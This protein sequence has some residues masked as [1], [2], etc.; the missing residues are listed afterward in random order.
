MQAILKVN[1]EIKS[2]SGSF[3][4][5]FISFQIAPAIAAGCSVVLKPSPL[6]SLSCLRF[7]E[8]T[9]AANIPSGIF[10]VLTG[11]PPGKFL[12]CF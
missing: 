6:A 4:P 1:L 5:L 12:S 7:A 9:Q 2:I 8:I 10:N 3:E 11:G